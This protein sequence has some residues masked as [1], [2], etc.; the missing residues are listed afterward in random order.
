MEEKDRQHFK[1]RLLDEKKKVLDTLGKMKNTMEVG[2]MDKYYT[3][4][5][6]YD[7]HPADIGTEVFMLEQDM[8]L[9]NKL[10][11]TLKEIESSL[12]RIDSGKYGECVSC[13]K[14]ID[15]QR[16]ELIPYLKHCIQC[17]EKNSSLVSE[18]ISSRLAQNNIMD[19]FNSEDGLDEIIRYN[20]VDKDPSYNT[21]DFVGVSEEENRDIVEE[22]DKISHG[23][24]KNTLK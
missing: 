2:I 22:V 20:K 4:L 6:M 8:G 13:G 23:Y 21:G 7:N 18:N 10:N 24:Y 3:E 1:K 14:K 11:H 12:D 16:L 5:S 17:T 15:R 19:R 9:V